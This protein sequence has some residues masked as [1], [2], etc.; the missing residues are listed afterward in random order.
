MSNRPPAS[1]APRR[2]LPERPSFE[3]L[4]KEAKRLAKA[5]AIRLAEA[6]Q[7]L[8]RSY[9]FE[10]WAALRA[11]VR[12]IEAP[13][14]P[15]PLAQAAREG[16]LDL[17]QRLLAEGQDPNDSESETSPLWEAC[18]SNAPGAV[19]LAIAEALLAAGAGARKGAPGERPLHAVALRG[20]VALAE[21]LI[22]HGAIEWEPNAKGLSALAIAR[23][24]RAGD[25]KALVELLDRPVIRDP[26]FR[27]AVDAIHAGDLAELARRLDAEPRLLTDRIRE[28]EC[29]RQAKRNQYFLDPKLF[30]FVANNPTLVERMPASTPDIARAMIARGPAQVTQEDLDVTLGLVMT[31]TNLRESGLQRALMRVL[32]EAGA[33]ARTEDM[34]GILAHGE[35][36]AVEHL[37]AAGMPLTAPIAAAL[38]RLD[39]LPGLLAKA[40]QQEIDGALD[41]AVI[42]NRLEAARLALRAGANPDRFS[43]QHTHS[44]PLHQAALH[45]SV[46]LLQLLIAHGARLD[47]VDTLWGGTPLG[48]AKH[49][50][51][52]PCAETIEFLEAKAAAGTG[53]AMEG[54]GV[55]QQHP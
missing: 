7:D 21:V 46:A 50:R 45:D 38:D 51:K 20:P 2:T 44:Q 49:G 22:A 27:A 39:V 33:R 26:A 42:N 16:D 52:P 17:V 37:V 35:T 23:R 24:S 41:L 25:R 29:Y 5:R 28:P 13:Q 47:V 43:S 40:S 8:A 53:H 19:R 34:P 31:S 18:T 12:S 6:Q 15:S 3:H 4:R 32:R 36:E 11:H 10:G 55:E 9:G 54:S 30:W 1:A 14:R 48:W